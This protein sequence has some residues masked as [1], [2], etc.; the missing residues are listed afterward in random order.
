MLYKIGQ[1]FR[2]QEAG[3]L[4]KP[5]AGYGCGGYGRENDK[6]QIVILILS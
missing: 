6:I 3:D 5:Q 2:P 1:M 4:T